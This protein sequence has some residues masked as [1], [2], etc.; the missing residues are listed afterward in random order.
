MSRYKIFE[1]QKIGQTTLV[2]HT[3]FKKLRTKEM[4]P[5]VL[6]EPRDKIKEDAVIESAYD[7]EA[8]KKLDAKDGEEE[9]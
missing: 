6:G 3:V 1:M 7:T 5:M 8:Q 2:D 9:R 4:K